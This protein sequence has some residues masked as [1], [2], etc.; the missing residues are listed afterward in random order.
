VEPALP[1]TPSLQKSEELLSSG[2]SLPVHENPSPE[3]HPVTVESGEHVA[4]VQP[5][6]AASRVSETA[7]KARAWRIVMPVRIRALS[8]E[9]KQ[10]FSAALDAVV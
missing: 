2:L 7:Q 8:K 6:P 9:R 4:V 5:V 10:S 3:T 1:G